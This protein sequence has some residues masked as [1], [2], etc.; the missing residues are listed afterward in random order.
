M[1][2]IVL[3]AG[4]VQDGAEIKIYKRTRRSDAVVIAYGKVSC[5]LFTL[6]RI[7]GGHGYI[8]LSSCVV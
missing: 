3:Y 2:M 7:A 5:A 1:M 6:Y 4:L 8:G